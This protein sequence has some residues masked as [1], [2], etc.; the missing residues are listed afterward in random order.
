[1]RRVGAV[2]L[3][4]AVMSSVTAFAG[5]SRSDSGRTGLTLNQMQV[6]GTHNSYHVEP[7]AE[8]MEVLDKVSSRARELAYSHDPLGV[9]FSD[10]GVRQIELDVHP[11]PTGELFD[12]I[13]T[14][15]FK[16][17]HME[18]VDTG[19]TCPTFIDC[20]SDI[21]T[22]SDANRSHM[23]IAVLVEIKDQQEIPLGPPPPAMT[24]ELYDALDAEIRS[25]FPDDR[26]ITP[27]LVRGNHE[28]LEQA[29][30]ED[31]WPLID[32]V[33]GRVMFLLDNKRDGY[34]EG[35]PS[36]EGRVAFTP[37]EPGQPDAAFVEVNDPRGENLSKIT[38]LVTRGYMVRTRADDPVITPTSGDTGQRDDAL[39]SG[40]QWVSTDYPV[41]GLASRWDG[42]T[43]VVEIPGGSPA[44]C[45]PVNAP[46]RC[47]SADVEDLATGRSGAAPDSRSTPA[48]PN[49]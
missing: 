3:V 19:T 5:C 23:P 22:W 12:P 31:G 18:R 36:L 30:L 45:N 40:A 46:D 11:D 8:S 13:G 49:G 34:T 17:F 25:V 15:G 29:V 10:Q 39:A 42:S 20:L 27:D 9:Q 6:V 37:S 35:H 26:L 33:R 44:R 24:A 1:M 21:R 32:D 28:T 38:D 16:V 43:Y 7:S 47:R 4:F 41:P 48:R 14:R 2:M